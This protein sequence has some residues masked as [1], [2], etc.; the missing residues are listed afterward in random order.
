MSYVRMWSLT[1]QGKV[2][3]RNTNN[4]D[5]VEYRIVHHMDRMGRPETIDQISSG[6]GIPQGTVGI[7]LGSLARNYKPPLVGV[8]G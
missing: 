6:T 2:V 4:P 1:Q 3:A 7:A 8:V 5:N